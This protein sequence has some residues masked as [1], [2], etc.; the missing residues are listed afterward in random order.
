MQS[1]QVEKCTKDPIEDLHTHTAGSRKPSAQAVQNS[2]IYSNRQKTYKA[3]DLLAATSAL[4][5][6]RP[7]SF[8]VKKYSL[9]ANSRAQGTGSL[10][11]P[12][13][14]GDVPSTTAASSR[15]SVS[16]TRARRLAAMAL[17]TERS[18][19]ERAMTKSEAKRCG[20]ADGAGGVLARRVQRSRSRRAA[21]ACCV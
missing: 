20:L 11:T 12:E 3:A 21:W 8:G 19:N 13:A 4:D 1:N 18:S 10:R 5:D 6:R 2:I 17:P 15:P 9:D 14:D 7:L 16:P